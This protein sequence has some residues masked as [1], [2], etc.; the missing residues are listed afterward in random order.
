MTRSIEEFKRFQKPKVAV[1]NALIKEGWGYERVSSKNQFDNNKS[2][3]NQKA[4][5]ARYAKDN[6]I[7]ISKVFGGTYES[8]SGDF[9]RKEFMRLINEVKRSR[10]R[11]K[12]IL[13]YI[14]SRFSRSGGNAISLANMLIEDLG[15][16]LVETSSGLN[17]E[18]EI[19]KILIYQKLLEAKKE[20]LERLKSTIPGMKAAMMEG[21]WLGAVPRGYTKYGP[22]VTDDKRFAAKTKIEVNEEGELLKKAWEWKLQG[23]KDYIIRQKL[24]NLGLK[25]TPG[26][27]YKIWRKPFYA[28]IIVHNI[29]DEPIKGNWE[30]LVSPKDFITINERL[31]EN[32]RQGSGYEKTIIDDPRPLSGHLICGSCKSPMY[33]Y[34]KRKKKKDG[35]INRM[36]YYKC[37]SCGEIHVN[38]N[39]SKF[40]SSKVAGLHD[41]FRS[42]LSVHKIDVKYIEPVSIV[43]LSLIKQKDAEIEKD[44]PVLKKR[45]TVLNSELK[46]IRKNWALGKI[47]P[48]TYDELRDEYAQEISSLEK[49]LPKSTVPYANLQKMILKVVTIFSKLDIVWDTVDSIQKKDLQKALFPKGL[50]VQAENRQ[51]RTLSSSHL[52]LTMMSF[53]DSYKRNK[54]G[55]FQNKLKKSLSAERGGLEPILQYH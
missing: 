52:M 47:D 12:Y 28:G 8:A 54:K 31:A 38:A 18:T 23:E 24:E 25:I 5:N 1:S 35:K 43:L 53:S 17:T 7:T 21:K 37:Y 51:L 22:N 42:I 33:G 44:V 13:I 49:Q 34:E 30:A 50:V 32:K 39:S 6:G 14:V 2:I 15:V 16:H 26:A 46:T 36:H 9:T 4:T 20:N 3:E 11:P 40:S 29:L 45:I 27:I 48:G 19:G 41:Q 10:K 55:T